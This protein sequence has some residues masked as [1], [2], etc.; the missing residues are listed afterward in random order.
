M[1]LI[2][3]KTSLKTLKFG[4]DRPGGGWSGQPYEQFYSPDQ[5]PP[6]IDLAYYRAN[7]GLDY[8]IRGGSNF[9]IGGGSLSTVAGQIDRDRIKKFLKDAPRGAAFV[10]KQVG[11][12]LT[13]PKI[14]TGNSVSV[15]SGLRD[16]FGGTTEVGVLENTRVYNGGAN[17]LVQVLASG[18]GTHIPRHGAFPIDT[19]AK[20]YTN[21]VGAEFL[22]QSQK[23]VQATNRLLIL[24]NLKL[25]SK[26]QPIVSDQE[27]D[28][29]VLVNQLGISLNNGLLFQYLGGPGSTY[30][31]GQTVIKRDSNSSKAY[32]L[33]KDKPQLFPNVFTMAYEQIQNMPIGSINTAESLAGNGKNRNSTKLNDFRKITGAPS[34]STIWDYSKGVD[35][36]F[37]DKGVDKLNKANVSDLIN[38]DPF[39]NTTSESDDIIKFGFECMSNDQPGQSV[40][41]I[42]RAFLTNGIN[43]SN[44]GEWNSFK[45]MGRGETFY[46]YQGFNRSIGFEFRIVAF[47]RD[48]MKP[49]YNKLNYL[50]SQVYPDYSSRGYMRAPI[51]KLTIGDYL[52]R[53]PGILE[54]VN[55]TVDNNSPWELTSYHTDNPIAQLPKVIDVAVSF[56]PIFDE[57]PRRSVKDANGTLGSAIISRKGFL[58]VINQQEKQNNQFN[59]ELQNAST[60][61]KF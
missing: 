57:L 56:K 17:T 60:N 18:T 53:V 43:D 37:Y 50:T 46:T 4:S 5:A 10:Q 47:S 59:A 24:Q 28:N 34:G 41:L 26:S 38:V 42:F 14:Q 22:L 15:I 7:D 12:Q 36:R 23:E 49:L 16:L 20:Y 27:V 30:G 44:S 55:L 19:N 39:E 9:Q 45:Y 52:Y 11:L 6:P 21:V 8:P 29:I 58:D 25:K 1:P 51:V 35:F 61:N 2:D 33:T 48:E 13:N 31:L 3:L 32:D 54:S 40:P